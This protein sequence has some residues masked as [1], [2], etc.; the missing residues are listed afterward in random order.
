MNDIDL[1]NKFTDMI[2]KAEITKKKNRQVG[3]YLT[4]KLLHSKGNNQ[5]SGKATYRTGEHICNPYT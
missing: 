2:P 4:E 3:L 5:Q 1:N